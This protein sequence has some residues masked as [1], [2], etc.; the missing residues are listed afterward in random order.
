[1]KGEASAPFFPHKGFARAVTA[2]GSALGDRTVIR[3]LW[4]VGTPPLL[5]PLKQLRGGWDLATHL[6][7]AKR[8]VEEGSLSG[9]PSFAV[10]AIGAA[11]CGRRRPWGSVGNASL[12]KGVSVLL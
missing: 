3:P 12:R 11:L 9:G 4:L 1:M 5:G 6:M 2:E 7:N 8:P 10:C